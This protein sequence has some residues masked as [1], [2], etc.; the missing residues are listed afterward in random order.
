MDPASSRQQVGLPNGGVLICY[1]PA[2]F[3]QGSTG[4]AVWYG[5]NVDMGLVVGNRDFRNKFGMAS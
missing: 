3:E 5:S 4:L 1:L 2:E